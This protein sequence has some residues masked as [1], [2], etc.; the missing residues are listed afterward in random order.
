M[1]TNDDGFVDQNGGLVFRDTNTNVAF[2]GEASNRLFQADDVY[3]DFL[4]GI[5]G[6]LN[7]Q[8][9]ANILIDF[10]NY[11]STVGNTVAPGYEPGDGIIDDGESTILPGTAEPGNQQVTV[12][13]AYLRLRQAS[14][15]SDRVT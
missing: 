4:L 7:D 8:A 5:K 1:A 3:N 11:L 2:P 12:W 15:P 6:R 13:E 14:V 10:G 9:T